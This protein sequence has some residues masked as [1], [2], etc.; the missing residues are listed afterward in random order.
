MADWYISSTAYAAVP[1]WTASHAYSVGNFVRG[2]ATPS[3]GR[4]YVFRCTT[5]G[6]SGTSEPPWASYGGNNN[7]LAGD[8]GV[9][10]TNVTGQG[11]Y[12]WSAAGRDF[13]TFS[14]YWGSA[15]AAPGD[16]MFASSDHVETDQGNNYNFGNGAN[17][18]LLQMLS[19][20]KAGSVPPVAAD[21]QSG[22]ALAW[23]TSTTVNL[24]ALVN[25]FWQGFTFS[26]GPTTAFT[27]CLNNSANKNHYF[28]NCA[29][30]TGTNAGTS[31]RNFAPCRVVM[32]NSTIQFGATA[33]SI[34][35][36]APL[37]WI[38]INTA[39]PLQGSTFP[40][41]LFIPGTNTP[42]T[43]ISRGVDFSAFT[44]NWFGTG[45]YQVSRHLLESCKILPSMTR[46]PAASLSGG[47]PSYDDIE[48]VNCFDGT[49]VINERWSA[50]GIVTTD[51][52]A[53][54]TSGGQ[55]DLGA[56]SFK[57]TS[58]SRSD[59]ATM[60]LDCF[61]FDIENIQTGT[62]KTATVEVVSSGSLNNTDLRL[63][64]EYMGSST[65]PVASMGDSLAS[66][67]T[68]AS[69]L[70]A[71][72]NTW[73]APAYLTWSPIDIAP[74]V[75]LSGGNL[76]ATTNTGSQGGVRCMNGYSTGKYY[77]EMS[78]S[79]GS[80]SSDV[81]GLALASSSIQI[82]L[83]SGTVEITTNGGIFYN[84]ANMGIT[85]AGVSATVKI[86]VAVD[87]GAKLV[88]FRASPSGAWNAGGSANP[89][90]GVGGQDITAI[91]TGPLYPFWVAVQSGDSVTANFG[92][93]AF[94]GAVPSGFT[95]GWP[96][97]QSKQLLQTTFSPQQI[98][99]VRG[100]VRLGRP[101]TTVWVNPQVTVT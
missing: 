19:V 92:A 16:R 63:L 88:W 32:D 11:A 41:T 47:S 31:F 10:W 62:S 70:P 21:L 23:T 61:P 14:W 27:I 53:Y 93:S 96:F 98:G 40:T 71:S 6:T 42:I 60:P 49:S 89:A 94:T 30:V 2:L 80:S 26:F 83:T 87:F 79:S 67:L 18:G 77:F 29:F 52:A 1:Q 22:A 59:F 82:N 84:G 9:S 4:G 65:S 66:V 34:N 37:D 13:F 99:R 5:A 8:G 56:Y 48:L 95:S 74:N 35:P 50:A 97:T 78:F 75:V 69:A 33:Q 76:T 15:R 55:D 3:A 28:K 7:L 38:W 20:N 73:T 44:G 64:I 45:Q 12:G 81:L 36:N 86:G 54:L 58:G 57:L 90:T 100:L 24:E 91:L 43:T 72:S 68:P 17:F 51:R 25:M 101:S 85:V 46:F 39:A